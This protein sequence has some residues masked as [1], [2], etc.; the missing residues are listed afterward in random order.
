MLNKSILNQLDPSPEQTKPILQ[1][2]QDIVV[3][4][5]AGT[6]KTRTLV[7]RYLSLLE[8]NVPLREIV[9]ITFTK[10]AAR[11][12]RNRIREEVRIY[13]HRP[14]LREDEQ[15][16]WRDIY[17]NLDA[18]R[19]S[20][21]HS[22]ATDILR[23]HPAELGLDPK[24]ELLD[25]GQAAR[26][27]AR[28]VE[29]ALAWGS[30]DSDA[31]VI[32]PLYGDWKLRKVISELLSKRLDIGGALDKSPD[33]IWQLWEPYLIKPLQSFVD[34]REVISAMDEFLEYETNGILERAHANGDLFADDLRIV[35]N[36][37]KKIKQARKSEDWITISRCLSPLRIHLKQ[38]GKKDNWAPGN[39]RELIKLIQPIFDNNITFDKLDLALDQKLAREIIPGIKAVFQCANQ[40]YDTAKDQL[41]GLD[42]D[43]LENFS[44]RL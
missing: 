34:D 31:A 3:S 14:D 19:I 17:E 25:E 15:R 36:S 29:A 8:E 1:R 23:Q 37:W 42:F 44:L 2:D 43:D 24:F 12:M 13:L 10:K 33:D 30:E 11:E 26:L 35:I 38:K 39:P 20:T 40:W 22:L 7:A 5:G 27:K 18:A 28:A 41:N 6:G 21:I 4:A 9:A 16:Y 32:F